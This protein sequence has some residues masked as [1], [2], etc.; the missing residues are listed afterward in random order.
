MKVENYY[1]ISSFSDLKDLRRKKR[2]IQWLIDQIELDLEERIEKWEKP[3][4]AMSNVGRIINKTTSFLPMGLT[5][6]A[7]L[8]SLWARK[9]KKKS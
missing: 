1:K 9:K 3:V 4:S 6:G 5:V 2:E 7:L 8:G